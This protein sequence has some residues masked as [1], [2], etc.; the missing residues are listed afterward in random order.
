VNRRAA[1]LRA[2]IP[3]TTNQNSR[4]SAQDDLR[5]LEKTAQLLAHHAGV[6]LIVPEP[7]GLLPKVARGLEGTQVG[8]Q[9]DVPEG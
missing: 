2:S 5:L 7:P 9:A 6:R 3:Y 8:G 4:G 1:T